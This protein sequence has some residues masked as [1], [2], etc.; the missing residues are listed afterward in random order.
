MRK[1]DTALRGI[2]LDL[3]RETADTQGLD[4]VNIRILAEKAGVATGTVYNYFSCKDEILLALTEEY[5]QKALLEMEALNTGA[6]FC[7]QLQE[8]Y[9]FL[10]KRIHQ[11]AGRLMNSLGNAETAGQERMVSMQSALESI[12]IRRMEQDPLVRRDIWTESFTKKQFAK[13]LPKNRNKKLSKK[14]RKRQARQRIVKQ[15]LQIYLALKNVKHMRDVFGCFWGQT[16]KTP[17][18]FLTILFSKINTA[19]CF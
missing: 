15:K 1:K 13:L 18:L 6:S 3:A 2:L 19:G 16:L 14:M 17:L 10:K 12:F 4:A 5:W 11:S 8:I 9:A 7:E